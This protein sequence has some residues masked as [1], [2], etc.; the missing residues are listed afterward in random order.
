[1]PYILRPTITQTFL[2]RVKVTPD[3]IGFQFKAGAWKEVSFRDFHGECRWLSFG[4]MNLGVRFG[5]R[6]AILSQTRYEW[7]LADMAIL[8]ARAVTVPIY[9]SSTADDVA[10]LLN[11]AEVKIAIVEDRT[12]LEKI[13]ARRTDLPA[14]EK[15]VVLDPLAMLIAHDRKDVLTVQALTE[16]GR[17]AEA[18]DPT[19]FDQNLREASPDDLVTICY[20]SG[21]TG[22]PK[23]VMISHDN[24][25]SV[26]EDVVDRIGK[27]ISP[28]KESLLAF[29]PFSHIIGK[30]ESLAAYTFGWRE[31]YA[32]NLDKIADN[33][34]EVRPTVLFAVPRI[35]EKAYTRILTAVEE[36]PEPKQRAFAWGLRVGRKYWQPLWNGKSPSLKARAEYTFARRTIFAPIRARFGGRLDY[37]VCGG[38]P[39]PKEIGEFFQIIGIQVLEGY[40]LTETTA[41]VTLNLPGASKFGSVGRPLPEVSIKLAADGEIQVRSRKVFKGYYK[42]PE[43]TQAAFDQGYFLTGDIGH[44]DSEGFLHITDR[45]KDIIITS[46]GKNIA[47]QKIENLA[48]VHKYISQFVVHGDGR[49]YLTALITLDQAATTQYAHDSQILFSD[50]A[51]LV[52]SPKL[53]ALVQRIVDDVNSKLASYETIK[54]FIIL[55]GDFTIE[56][57]ELTPSLKVKRAFIEKRYRAELDVLY[58]T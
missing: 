31:C 50:F 32:E 49:H 29:L 57:G 4:L 30:V 52:S 20:T 14:L 15:I 42:M 51:G 6:V 56:S 13:L 45:K 48:K 17:R 53:Q 5:D 3:A 7:A 25:M 40:G 58:S 26:L 24:V 43:E 27:L 23:G 12:Q 22:V 54:K 39:L 55:P 21:T 19:R 18:N 28:E 10:F 9:A 34:V 37:A 2:E 1:V 35:F 36:M 16:I 44:I 38:A 11:H 33:M 41:P 46:G 47:P 8:G